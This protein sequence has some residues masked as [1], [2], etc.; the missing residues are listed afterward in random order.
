MNNNY[1]NYYNY[2]NYPS[3]GHYFA[4]DNSRALTL[5]LASA[6][7]V[8]LGVIIMNLIGLLISSLIVK[9][10]I[11]RLEKGKASNGRTVGILSVI[12]CSWT[13]ATVAAINSMQE[14]DN[15]WLVILAYILATVFVLVVSHCIT[16]GKIKTLEKQ[17]KGKKKEEIEKWR[18]KYSSGFI[19]MTIAR[20]MIGFFFA[21]IVVG[22]YI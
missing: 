15:A 21:T 16:M 10:N 12:L 4:Q 8:F 19:G 22:K 1:N 6:F 17:T 3:S 5:S 2:N 9:S 20:A 13:P 7:G 18:A 14:G 11:K